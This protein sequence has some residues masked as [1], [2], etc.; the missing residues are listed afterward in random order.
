MYQFGSEGIESKAESGRLQYYLSKDEKEC[1]L[2][3]ETVEQKDVGT[4][5]CHVTTVKDDLGIVAGK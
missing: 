5:S 3:I 4:W 1:G 2:T